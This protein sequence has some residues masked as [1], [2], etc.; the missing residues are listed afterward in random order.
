MGRWSGLGAG[1][2]Y[3]S[4]LSLLVILQVRLEGTEQAERRVRTMRK[5]CL[6]SV[7][8]SDEHAALTLWLYKI[9][10]LPHCLFTTKR[11]CVNA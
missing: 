5:V 11:L 7:C 6:A 8:P 9:A 3:G 10:S 1:V 4:P 2:I